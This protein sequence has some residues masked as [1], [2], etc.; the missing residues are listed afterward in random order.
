MEVQAAQQVQKSPYQTAGNFDRRVF[1]LICPFFLYF[2]I[3]VESSANLISFLIH[4]TSN[5]TKVEEIADFLEVVVLQ[6]EL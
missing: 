6:C 5:F 1:I 3:Y 2:V 4:Q